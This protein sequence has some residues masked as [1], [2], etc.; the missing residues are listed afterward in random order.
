MMLYV[1]ETKDRRFVDI[2][3]GFET[4]KTMNNDTSLGYDEML[5]H[6]TD[7]YSEYPL[8]ST[9]FDMTLSSM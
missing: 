6:N 1:P 7:Q 9:E 8:N 5:N 4:W 3:T 2:S